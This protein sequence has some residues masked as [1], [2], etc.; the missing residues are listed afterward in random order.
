MEKTILIGGQAGQGSAVT[1]HLIGKIFCRLGYFVFNYR[2]YPSLIRGGHNF[3]I[4]RI[5]DRPVYSH[6]EK[7]DF[8]LAF[9]QKTIDLHQ[10]NLVPGGVIFGDKK[11]KG[12]SQPKKNQKKS[13]TGLKKDTR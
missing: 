7:Y 10:K 11:L 2:D 9:D 3:N 1:S 4:L 8:I 6:L 12:N 13:K 5:S